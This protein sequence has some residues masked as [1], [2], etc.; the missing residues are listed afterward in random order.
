MDCEDR[1][2]AYRTYRESFDGDIGERYEWHHH[3]DHG[4]IVTNREYWRHDQLCRDFTVVTW[5]HGEEYDR[6]GTACRDEDG[7]WRFL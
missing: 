2:Y 7:D 6:D 1:P 3:H 4:Y 5:H